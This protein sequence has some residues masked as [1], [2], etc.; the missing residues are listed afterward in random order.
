MPAPRVRTRERRALA[1]AI[2]V[3]RAERDLSQ[4]TV[5]SSGGLGANAVGRMESGTSAPGF[6][7]LVGAAEGL[8]ISLGELIA[9]YERQLAKP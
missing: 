2:R 7:S 5:E 9:E 8:G 1:T 3:L 4:E 6:D